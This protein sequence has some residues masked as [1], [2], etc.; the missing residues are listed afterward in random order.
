M[1]F[2]LSEFLSAEAPPDTK[3]LWFLHGHPLSDQYSD[4]SLRS[5][6][7][8]VEYAASEYGQK[9]AFLYP[10][11]EKVDSPYQ[12]VSWENFNRSTDAVAAAYSRQ[13]LGVL[14]D[15]NK[16]FIQP[17]VAVLGR[18]T[19]I[20]FYMT[21]IAL[22]K[23]NIRALLVIPTLPPAM[24]QTLLDRCGVVGLIFDQEYSETTLSAPCRLPMIEDPCSLPS[25][26]D[27]STLIRFEDDRDPWDRPSIIV[28]SSGSTGSP[29]PIVHTNRSLLLMARTYRLF[30]TFHVQNWYH[31][32]GI[33]G[34]AGMLVL[35]SGFPYGLPTVFP[36]R[37]MPPS[38]EAFLSAIATVAKMGHPV[39]GLHTSPQL[40]EAI[41]RRISNTTGDFS[42]LRD[43]RTVL[44]GGAPLSEAITQKMVDQGVNVG[45]NYGSSELGVLMR[46]YPPD[47]RASPRI[48][49]MRYFAVPGIK[50][51]VRM[52]AVDNGLS[53]L[54]VDQGF[55][56]AAEVWGSGLGA[57]AADGEVMRSNDLFVPDEEMMEG[58]NWILKGRRDDML[59]LTSGAVNVAAVEVET[60]IIQES[61]GLV[62]AAML[63]GHGRD[64]TGLLVELEENVDRK[65]ED[66]SGKIWAVVEKVNGGMK[67][68][69]RVGR[70][71]L[72]ILDEGQK[73]PLGGKGLVKRKNAVEVYRSEIDGLYVS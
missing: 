21:V 14:T 65:E 23:L 35:P 46:T 20:E 38:P 40:L 4:P 52:E 27:P 12:T 53:E 60:A 71:M 69:A 45:Q 64:R 17:T 1:D 51:H 28:H 56:S 47:D 67:D 19:S 31:L 11:N 25:S 24:I 61:A 43:L 7:A 54:V 6:G 58:G 68:K 48:A 49:S 33:H 37:P 70:E 73:L 59:I 22:Q 57:Q 9:T 8:L 30:A 55:P 72:L 62:K 29:K 2:D 39:D 26:I 44:S 32:F 5:I 41:M 34:I 3:R 36:P 15:A 50:T 63:V 66:V 13:L 10:L 16:T 18:G 42:P